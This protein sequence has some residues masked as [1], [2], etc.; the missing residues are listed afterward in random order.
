MGAAAAKQV[1]KVEDDIVGE[2]P[3]QGKKETGQ[4]AG[5]KLSLTARVDQI[6]AKYIARSSS[7]FYRFKDPKYCDDLVILTSKALNTQ[8]NSFEL[9]EMDESQKSGRESVW[10]TTQSRARDLGLRRS[11]DKTKLCQRIARF[12]VQIAHV[13]AA[14]QAAVKPITEHADT[15]HGHRYHESTPDPKRAACARRLAAL[16]PVEHEGIMTLEPDKICRINRP[17]GRVEDGQPTTVSMADELAPGFAKLEAL[18]EDKWDEEKGKFSGRSESMKAKYEA[19]VV[20]FFKAFTGADP[21][22]DENGKSLIKHFGSIQLTPYQDD[23]KCF[24][25]DKVKGLDCGKHVGAKSACMA[26]KGCDWRPGG[27]GDPGKCVL[28]DAGL[29]R[30]GPI[31]APKKGLKVFEAYGN[32]YKQ[33]MSDAKKNKE[34]LNKILDQIFTSYADTELTHKDRITL[35]PDLTRDKL[36]K[37]IEET[38]GIL[39]NLYISCEKDFKRGVEL[40]DKIVEYRRDELQTARAEELARL[41]HRISAGEPPPADAT[42]HRQDSASSRGHHRHQHEDDDERRR[43]EALR[44]REEWEAL[45]REREFRREEREREERRLERERED[46][47]REDRRRRELSDMYRYG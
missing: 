4:E 41:E 6:A 27:P 12:Y 8:L 26:E 28:G 23:P 44:R 42:G 31:R 9:A 13:F 30:V 19:D 10:V 29:Y 33:M 40:L 38:R 3:Q 17:R 21:A 46:R 45:E 37:I 20:A 16:A 39:T 14:I 35:R 43:V 5:P 11:A 36:A 18:Y 7:D 2:G 1:E 15:R 25:M 24:K 32:H 22:L 34:S 47:R